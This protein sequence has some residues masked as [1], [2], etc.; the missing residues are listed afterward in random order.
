[1]TNNDMNIELLKAMRGVWIIET[2]SLSK[3]IKAFEKHQANLLD[4]EKEIS[5]ILKGRFAAINTCLNDLIAII[6]E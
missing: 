1:M 3:K 2:E 4:Q 6:G 5:L